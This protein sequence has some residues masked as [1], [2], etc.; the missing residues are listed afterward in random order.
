MKWA[1]GF[2]A[3]LA[4]V[5]AIVFAVA[6][7]RIENSMNLVLPHEVAAIS[8]AA[9]ELH[10]SLTIGDLHADSAIWQRDLRSRSARGHVDLPRLREGNVA[11]QAF[12]IVSKSPSARNYER[13]SADAIDTITILAVLQRWPLRTW[14]SL[15]E[16]A[17]YQAG[18]LS[19]IE[20]SDPGQLII[21][22][23]R[24]DLEALLAARAGGAT[25]VGALIGVEGAH[26]L[27]DNLANLDRFYDVG[28]RM[29]GLQHFFDNAL[30]GSL[31]GEGGHGLT[32]FGRAVVSRL[33]ERGIIIDVAHSS[34]ESVSDTLDLTDRPLVVSHTGFQGHCATPRNIDD[35]LMQRIAAKGGLIGVGYWD[36]AVCDVSPRGI[37]S[38]IR[39]GIDLVGVDHVALGSDYDGTVEVP[40]DTSELAVLTD[41]MLQEGFSK[42][43]IRKVMGGNFVRFLRENL[44]PGDSVASVVSDDSQNSAWAVYGEGADYVEK[45]RAEIW[46]KELAVYA[47]RGDGN[48]QPYL[49]ALA[50][51]YKAWPP[52]REVPAG[53]AGLEDLAL[54]MKGQDQ[55]E[56]AMTFL[57][58][59]LNGDTATI[60]YKTH[61]TRLPD[62]SP[63]NDFYEVIHVWVIEEGVWRVFAGMARDRPERAPR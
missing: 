63:A 16:R 61:R 18:K 36:A 35:A 28:I 24:S 17:L 44:P 39:Y 48:L 33:D 30:G 11:L 12:T 15:T 52:F 5:M 23:D 43:E 25:T 38:A 49:D 14:T 19:A 62:G 31:H 41:T 42:T 50:M 6:P 2:L 51:D 53:A 22:R 8:N 45:V 54:R 20:V 37:V 57:D 27:D 40:F 13:N 10:A 59:S 56:L 47:G 46:E 21:L 7:G 1:G 60:Y 32:A 29:I 34:P 3:L 55:E 4:V 9:Q 58:F 26:A